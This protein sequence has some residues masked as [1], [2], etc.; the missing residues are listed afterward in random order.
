[1]EL[2]HEFNLCSWLYHTCPVGVL[3][4]VPETVDHNT[5][6]CDLL[7]ACTAAAHFI[8][9]INTGFPLKFG[10]LF[11]VPI[12]ASELKNLIALPAN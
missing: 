6:P 10:G 12:A 5:C 3:S 1:M 7:P 4:D 11:K 9:C 2:V 8:C